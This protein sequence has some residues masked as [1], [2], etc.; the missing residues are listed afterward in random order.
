MFLSNFVVYILEQLLYNYADVAL[1]WIC[2]AAFTVVWEALL[3]VL[4]CYVFFLVCDGLNTITDS[5]SAVIS[6]TCWLTEYST[7]SLVF[8]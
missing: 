5:N 6:L 7:L 2:E 3:M 1:S 8:S 4:Y